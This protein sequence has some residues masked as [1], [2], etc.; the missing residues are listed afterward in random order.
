MISWF[1]FNNTETF[2]NICHIKRH[3][4]LAGV[5]L[6]TGEWKTTGTMIVFS[7][8]TQHNFDEDPGSKTEAIGKQTLGSEEYAAELHCS[9][10]KS[11]GTHHHPQMKWT[12]VNLQEKRFPEAGYT[13]M[14]G[15]IQ[16]E[17]QW[18]EDKN[19]HSIMV[20]GGPKKDKIYLI[21]NN[22]E[23]LTETI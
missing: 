1:F 19:P 5:I 3:T 9:S 4:L 20:I 10:A 2:K 6:C 15:L 18:V 8:H 23:T 12:N 11:Q 7:K 22:K 14:A 17:L 13:F 16:L 21:Q